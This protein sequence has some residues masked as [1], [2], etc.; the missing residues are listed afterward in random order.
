M[1]EAGADIGFSVDLGAAVGPATR[2]TPLD[3]RDRFR[4]GAEDS[5]RADSDEKVG[6]E[7]IVAVGGTPEP[8]EALLFGR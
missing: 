4:F 6:G 1:G 5:R 3:D 8:A 7:K 2:D